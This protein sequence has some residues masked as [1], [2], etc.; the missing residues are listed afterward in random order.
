MPSATSADNSSRVPRSF[1][2]VTHAASP[3]RKV[4][5]RKLKAF[6]LNSR[7]ERLP[8]A[9]GVIYHA[10]VLA[11]A[12]GAMRHRPQPVRADPGGEPSHGS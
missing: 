8:R 10:F 7:C 11:A 5:L 1:R 4:C 12:F 6:G 2:P 9:V 3:R